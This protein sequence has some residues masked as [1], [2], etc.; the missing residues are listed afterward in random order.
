MGVAD[1][2]RAL[3]QNLTASNFYS[4]VA[5]GEWLIL[6]YSP[7][8]GACRAFQPE[9]EKL[10]AALDHERNSRVRM[11]ALDVD[12]DS[13]IALRHRI[14]G[15]PT[16]LLL[17]GGHTLEYS[18]D[19]TAAAIAAFGTRPLRD[20]EWEHALRWPGEPSFVETLRLLPESTM[21]LGSFAYSTSERGIALLI[22]CLSCLLL[23]V[24]IGTQAK[25]RHPDFIIVSCP[26]GIAPG[27]AFLVTYR[28]RQCICWHQRARKIMVIAPSGVSVGQQFVVPL[29]GQPLPFAEPSRD[30]LKDS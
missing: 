26:A 2:A 7:S 5:T 16:I 13:Q 6:F 24:V 19:W 14:F 22:A 18:G 29:H 17:R 3:P 8:C 21:E 27:E 23:G 15:Y 12:A 25:H 10:P 28:Q 1:A 9:W 4:S 11:G 30:K 20:D